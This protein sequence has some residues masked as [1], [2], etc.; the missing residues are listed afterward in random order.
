MWT[1]VL[2]PLLEVREQ[3]GGTLVHSVGNSLMKVL[4]LF[5]TKGLTLVRNPMT[6]A[7]VGKASIIKQTSTNM[8]E[9]TQERSLIPVLS[10][11]KISVRI[12]I[13]VAMK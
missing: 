1:P 2:L 13:G 9:S 12:L 5:L 6:V 4:T 10:V 7:T 3:G 11:E 8:N